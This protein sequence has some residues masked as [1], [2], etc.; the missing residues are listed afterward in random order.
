M[1]TQLPSLTRNDA[2]QFRQFAEVKFQVLRT[3]ALQ[4]G[5]SETELLTG[6]V[7]ATDARNL[8]AC[9][10]II[11]E[12][13]RSLTYEHPL[14]RRLAESEP[15]DRYAEAVKNTEAFELAARLLGV[16]VTRKKHDA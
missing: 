16:R 15:V 8:L 9:F 7:T 11:Q 6:Q 4:H 10:K 12:H 3:V 1:L 14:A 2:E 13:D 5:H